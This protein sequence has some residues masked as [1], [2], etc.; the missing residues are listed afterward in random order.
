MSDFGVFGQNA[1]NRVEFFRKTE[2]I[3]K[4]LRELAQNVEGRDREILDQASDVIT[5]L[6]DK[7]MNE[8]QEYLRKVMDSDD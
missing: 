1:I 6:V 5:K 7:K 8:G 3:L 2:K 4:Y